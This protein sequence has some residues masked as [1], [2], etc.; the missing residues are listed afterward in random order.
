M[1]NSWFLGLKLFVIDIILDFFYW[2]IWWYTT[3]LKN[4]LLFCGRQIK[5]A[6]RAL[7]LGI[8]LYNMFT[9]MYGDRSILG[10]AIS[11]VVRL[12]VLAWRLVWM[13]LW[14]AIIIGLLI[15]WLVAPI[16]TVWIIMEHIEILF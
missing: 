11:F 12:V 16:F 1:N 4:S 8:W 14:L 13:L 10:R 9:P 5:E 2:P 6:W 7:A 15:I 3:G